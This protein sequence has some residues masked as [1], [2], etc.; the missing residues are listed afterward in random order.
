MITTIQFRFK[1]RVQ[2]SR[3]KICIADVRSY[4]RVCEPASST[5]ISG[6]MNV[7]SV[8]LEVFVTKRSSTAPHSPSTACSSIQV[9]KT[10]LSARSTTKGIEVS[11]KGI[12]RRKVVITPNIRHGNNLRWSFMR[13]LWHIQGFKLFLFVLRSLA[14]K[15]LSCTGI[16]PTPPLPLENRNQKHTWPVH[17]IRPPCG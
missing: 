17:T 9:I 11:R 6:I 8:V 12:L 15:Y 5:G 10:M 4:R 16:A 2:G 1:V 7:I 13:S 14:T 3:S